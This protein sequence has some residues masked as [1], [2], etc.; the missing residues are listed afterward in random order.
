M[1]QAACF[2]RP[3]IAKVLLRYGANP[4]LRDEDG[5]T[6]LDKARERNDEGHRE[7][8]AILQSPGEW[9]IPT[10]AI[11]ALS[12][13]TMDGTDL[14]PS[15]P[16]GSGRPSGTQLRRD[17][18]GESSGTVSSNLGSTGGAPGAEDSSIAGTEPKG[19]PDMAP[20]YLRR[21]LPVFCH[22]FQS[23]MIASVRKA[24]LT[25]IKKMVH[26]TQPTLLNSLASQESSLFISTLVEVVAAVLDN[27]EDED[28]H[29][30]CLHVIQDLMNKSAE[31]FLDHF[32]RLGIFSKVQMLAN[33]PGDNDSDARPADDD[34]LANE[35]E[36][37]PAVAEIASAPSGDTISRETEPA[38]GTDDSSGGELATT[39]SPATTSPMDGGEPTG[40][41]MTPSSSSNPQ[42]VVSVVNAVN[43]AN[44]ANAGQV[45]TPNSPADVVK[46][47]MTGRPYHW[48]DWCIARGRDCLY[49]WSDA[50][51]LELSN[52]S[53][54][55]FRF[56]LDG[57]L[58]TMYSSGSTE[59][60]SDSSENRGEFLDKLQRVRAIIKPGTPSQAVFPP[61]MKEP[62]PRLTVGNWSLSPGTK[63]GE[64]IIQNSD[65]QQ[66]ATILREDLPGFLFESNRGTK[67]TFTAETAL[68]PELAAGWAPVP[69]YSSGGGRR[70]VAGRAGLVGGGRFRS[71]QVEATKQK[72]RSQAQE[73]YQRYFQVAQAQP[74]G[75]V[76]RLAAIVVHIERGCAA[77]ENNREQQREQQ[78]REHH[79]HHPAGSGGNG[80]GAWR[81]LLRSALNDLRCLLEEDATLS[82]FELQSSGLVQALHRLLSPAGLDDYLQGTRRGMRLLR[83]RV[84]IFKECFQST[85]AYYKGPATCLARKLVA[86]LES[87]EKLPVYLYDAA[88]GST[89]GLQTLTRRLRFR[90][91]RC[92]G[93]T[94][95][96]DR[97]GRTL[98]TEPL[99]TVSQ[100]EKYLLKMVA[101]QWYDYE[102]S[103]LAFVRK[104][105]QQQQQH[106][107]GPVAGL[108]FRHTRDFDEGG[109]LYWIGTNGKTVPDWVNPAQVG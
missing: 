67:H 30:V 46:E 97:S 27:E 86:V 11:P 77:Q 18:S 55:W 107:S 103:S 106:Q 7:V 19:D 41:T 28:G 48:R 38:A 53:N 89:N 102:R 81:D 57:K 45:S 79:H 13:L 95:L 5:K 24:S 37:T 90:L 100:L 66:Q 72:V 10:S 20:V 61:G 26:Y 21:L 14:P 35:T 33:S 40:E 71:S 64:L 98:K 80:H 6:P 51:A 56:I 9:M 93:E 42:A 47:L 15:P 34:Q 76:A 4:D 8:A 85:D 94:G 23:S 43:A 62:L 44:A 31:T 92:P 25:I 2:G 105:Q 78:Q 17:G 22:T 16:L 32:A 60:G 83:Q 84:A 12:S 109:V 99:T 74:R 59:G 101:K 104:I 87:I 49:I 96:T 39:I 70:S 50:A 91:E 69:S 108:T 58:A 1:I 36:S 29:L 73:I 68:G 52:G 63:D 65:G 75:V 82:A 88:G 3:A 54:G